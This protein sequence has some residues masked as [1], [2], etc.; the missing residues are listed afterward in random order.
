VTRQADPKPA[1]AGGTGV[2][3]DGWTIAVLPGDGIGPEVTAEAVRVLLAA[4]ER[5]GVRVR[6]R[7]GRIGG[8]A[9]D[10]TGDPLPAET[11]RLCREADAVLLGAVGGP[12]WDGLSQEHRPERGLLRL[13]QALKVYANLR[14]VR[15]PPSLVD[16]SPLR[17]ERVGGTDLVIVRELTGGAYFG[18]PRWY[19]DEEAVDTI[20]YQAEEIRR[21]ARVAFALARGRRREVV[22]VDKANVLATSALWRT[23]VEAE[24]R[25]YPDVAVRHLLVDACALELVRTPRRFDVILTENLFGDILSDGAA[26]LVGSLGLLPSASVGETHPW[27]Y[28]P[29]HGS[30]P[31]LAGRGVANPLGAILSVAMMLRGSLGHPELAT[32]VEQAV[33]EVLRAGIR[34]PDLGG[35]AATAD[36]GEAVAAALQEGQP[37]VGG[38]PA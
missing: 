6:L 25:A 8:A 17:P 33:D 29:V 34:T 30:A 9:L 1:G 10:A 23:V 35:T 7:E 22:S 24:A 31:D 28:E 37:L 4:A 18:E 5:A 12:R 26:G 3:P 36:V 11:L 27:L 13:R 32:A 15:L 20:R 38:R 2:R 16:V 14:P 19:R 21:V